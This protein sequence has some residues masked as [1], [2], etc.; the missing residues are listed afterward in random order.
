MGAHH[1]YYNIQLSS[2]CIMTIFI[3]VLQSD[4]HKSHIKIDS[5]YI[6]LHFTTLV[7]PTVFEKVSKHLRKFKNIYILPTLKRP[8]VSVKTSNYFACSFDIS[9]NFIIMTLKFVVMTSPL[10]L[11]IY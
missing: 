2:L 5:R 10:I 7:I 4:S 3:I 9:T 11:L 1:S 6:Y 8:T